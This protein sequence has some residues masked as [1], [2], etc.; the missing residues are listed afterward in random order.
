[1]RKDIENIIKEFQ[2]DRKRVFE[3]S[4]YKYADIIRKIEKTFV[5]NSG[6]IHWSNMGDGFQ[7]QWPCFY[8]DVSQQMNWYHLL[9]QI[10]LD[11]KEPI[12]VLFED[13][14][15]Y[16]PKYWLYEMYIPELIILIDNS[17]PDDFYLV[18]KKYDWL[19]SKCHEEVVC[20]LGDKLNYQ[21]LK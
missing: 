15:D 14:V 10:I 17:N 18:S 20:F 12:Y 3:V 8:K 13:T 4:K 16:Q 5:K 2:L 1:M 6:N 11:N 19:I 7:S 21:V 9:S